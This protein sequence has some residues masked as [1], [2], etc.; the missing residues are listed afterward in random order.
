[1]SE[2]IAPAELFPTDFNTI[3]KGSNYKKRPLDH[4]FISEIQGLLC[5]IFSDA[6]KAV[7]PNKQT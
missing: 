2:R 3:F 6:W 5:F 1:M 4:Q 7:C